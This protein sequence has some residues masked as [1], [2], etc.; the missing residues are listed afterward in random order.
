MK[1]SEVLM[2]FVMNKSKNDYWVAK[3]KCDEI[4]DRYLPRAIRSALKNSTVVSMATL[5]AAL[6][7]YQE[8]YEALPTEGRN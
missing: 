8:K 3:E 6:K 4:K 5:T 2:K 7:H 1:T